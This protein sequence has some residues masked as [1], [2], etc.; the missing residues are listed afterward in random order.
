MVKPVEGIVTTTYR[1]NARCVMCNIWKNPSDPSDEI[2]ASDLE[3]L[4]SLKGINVTGGEPFLREDLDEIIEVLLSK[5]DRV[6]VS[7]NGYYT[8]RIVKLA[9]RF[10]EV[11]YRISLEGLREANDELR[12]LKGGFDHAMNS[13][14][15]LQAMGIKDIGIAMT[16]SDRNAEDLLG[17]YEL[18]D[19]MGIEF[20]TAVVH[21]SFYF[22]KFD[23]RIDDP[24]LVAGEFKKLVKRLLGTWSVKNW[25]RAYFNAG[26]IERVRGGG[27]PLPCTMGT[28]IFFVGPYGDVKP[29]NALDYTI[30]NIKRDDFMDIWNGPEAAKMRE[31]VCNCDKQCWMIGSASPVMKKNFWKVTAWVLKAKLTGKIPPVGGKHD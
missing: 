2:K 5:G 8:D 13:L 20:A 12:G 9:K 22:H 25:Y 6:V 17:M 30:G 1:C 7:T 29:C 15:K 31:A 23:N 3:S 19:S 18:A 16:V 4:P 21:N 14:R 24:S 26:I 27:R 10:P 28:D 11:G